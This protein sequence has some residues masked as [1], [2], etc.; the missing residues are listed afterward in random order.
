MSKFDAQQDAFI[1]A[2][3][4]ATA[5]RYESEVKEQL[6]KKGIVVSGALAQSIKSSSQAAAQGH[7]ELALEFL[8]YGRFVDMGARVGYNKGKRVSADDRTRALKGK[9]PKKNI[10]Y[11]RIKMGQFARLAHNLSNKYVA[12]TVNILKEMQPDGR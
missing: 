7:G 11:S 9:P 8:G 12:T 10:F 3:T 6:T 4:Q 2:E 5:E 1:T